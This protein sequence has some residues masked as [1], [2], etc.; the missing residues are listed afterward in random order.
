[1][2]ERSRVLAMRT[3]GVIEKDGWSL[4]DGSRRKRKGAREGSEL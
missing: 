2:G 1:M 4:T 3:R